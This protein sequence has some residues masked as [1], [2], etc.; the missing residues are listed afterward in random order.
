[1]RKKL[2]LIDVGQASGANRQGFFREDIPGES[3]AK[4]IGPTSSCL[5]PGQIGEN[6]NAISVFEFSLQSLGNM[7][8]AII[9]HHRHFTRQGLR[10]GIKDGARELRESP[11]KAIQ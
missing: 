11:R 8:E 3:I 7:I 6:E 9:D 1:L 2:V 5:S 4:K 10:F